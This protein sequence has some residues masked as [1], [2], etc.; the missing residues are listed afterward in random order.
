MLSHYSGAIHSAFLI[1]VC[2]SELVKIAQLCPAYIVS[3]IDVP[4]R[5]VSS[6]ITHLT[7]PLLPHYSVCRKLVYRVGLLTWSQNN[8]YAFITLPKCLQSLPVEK[9]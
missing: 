6:A 9:I 2:M 8:N 4:Q 7:P 3:I 5:S 1:P